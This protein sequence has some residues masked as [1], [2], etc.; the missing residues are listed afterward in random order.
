M[1]IDVNSA[2]RKVFLFQT[3]DMEAFGVFVLL[4]LALRGR[5]CTSLISYECQGR[6]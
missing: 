4:C 6:I 5:L 1:S 2:V 3:G